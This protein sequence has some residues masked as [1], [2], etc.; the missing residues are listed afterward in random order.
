MVLIEAGLRKSVVADPFLRTGK[1][2]GVNIVAAEPAEDLACDYGV[3]AIAGGLPR[4]EARVDGR[5]RL[6]RLL[7]EHRVVGTGVEAAGRNRRE[8]AIRRG[9]H[10]HQ[11]FEHVEA[12]T[13]HVGFLQNVTRADQRA[14]QVGVVIGQ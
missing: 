14:R 6:D 3:A 10:L 12:D 4:G 9:L 2:K 7:V 11:T 13:D 8:A 5:E 1:R